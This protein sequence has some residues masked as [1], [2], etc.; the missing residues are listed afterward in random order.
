[1]IKLLKCLD[2]YIDGLRSLG[3]ECELERLPVSISEYS[4]DRDTIRYG[5]EARLGVEVCQPYRYTSMV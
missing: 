4:E 3:Q 5:R 2:I 1:M